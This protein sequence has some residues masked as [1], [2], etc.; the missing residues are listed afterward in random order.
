[1]GDRSTTTARRLLYATVAALV[2][3][4]ALL[5]VFRAVPGSEVMRPAGGERL[6][7]I[8]TLIGVGVLA[9]GLVYWLSKPPQRTST[10][11]GG[12][13]PPNDG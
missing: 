8:C 5:V 10:D 11:P 6:L 4:G 3:V 2:V 12:S 9:W 13:P 1:M 7:G